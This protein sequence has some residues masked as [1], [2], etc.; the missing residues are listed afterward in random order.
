MVAIGIRLQCQVMIFQFLLSHTLAGFPVPCLLSTL[1]SWTHTPMWENTGPFQTEVPHKFQ[2][3]VDSSKQSWFRKRKN[4]KL[5]TS[6]PAKTLFI[7]CQWWWL[8]HLGNMIGVW[9][10]KKICHSA[11]KKW[12]VWKS[13]GYLIVQWWLS[14]IWG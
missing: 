6:V 2:F 14:G 1:K 5:L 9:G 11:I 10:K 7:I 13:Q 3:W 8:S 12:H 4:Y